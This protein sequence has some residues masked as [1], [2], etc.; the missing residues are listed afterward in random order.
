MFSG[1]PG[2][3]GNWLEDGHSFIF[4]S[5]PALSLVQQMVES[6]PGV[7]LEQHF[8]VDY[9]DWLGGRLEAISI[10][11]LEFRPAWE[12]ACSGSEES[13]IRFDPGVVF[14]SGIHPTTR[15]CLR[16]LDMAFAAEAPSPV[17]DLGSGSGLLSLAS[18]KLGAQQV[19]AVDCNPLAARTTRANALRNGL[20]DKIL[21]LQGRA[22]DFAA[23][24]AR[25][26]AANIHFDILRRLSAMDAFW[27]KSWLLISGVL[28]KQAAWLQGE[29]SRRAVQ[30][31]ATWGWVEGWPTFLLRPGHDR[32]VSSD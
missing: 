12:E 24:P 3:L 4:F 6:F 25:L 29:F 30:V 10:G 5:Q 32:P 17:V 19:V 11:R 16:A 22:E 21:S 31:V 20:E 13:T 8:D 26:L 28:P 15:N 14:G 1:K 23:L 18:A 27:R 2:F 7:H 9:Q